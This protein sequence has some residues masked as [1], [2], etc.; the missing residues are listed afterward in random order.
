MTLTAGSTGRIRGVVPRSTSDLM[1]WLSIDLRN[2]LVVA[3]VW[4]DPVEYLDVTGLAN[5]V[6]NKLCTIS[7]QE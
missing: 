4:A 7:T 2:G 6:L 3:A 5:R 1:P